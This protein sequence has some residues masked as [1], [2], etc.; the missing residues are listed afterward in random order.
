MRSGYH[1][2]RFGFCCFMMWYFL[3]LNIPTSWYSP[4]LFLVSP[5]L[6]PSLSAKYWDLVWSHLWLT[7]ELTMSVCGRNVLCD[8]WFSLEPRC[9]DTTFGFVHHTFLYVSCDSRTFLLWNVCM[10]MNNLASQGGNQFIWP[11]RQGEGNPA[12]SSPDWQ[13]VFDRESV[14]VSASQL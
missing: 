13:V 6:V 4:V 8:E 3:A 5:I 12:T 10:P 1:R 2:D 9:K 11:W 14:S 7:E